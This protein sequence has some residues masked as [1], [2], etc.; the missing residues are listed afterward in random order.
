M[1][2]HRIPTL[3]KVFGWLFTICI[4]GNLTCWAQAPAN[5]EPGFASPE[6]FEAIRAA[7]V[8][9]AVRITDEISLD[10]RL[11]EAAWKLAT[12]ATDFYQHVPLTG[13]PAAERTEVFFLYDDNNL[14]MGVICYYLDPSQIQV[15]ELK[16]DF[17]YQ[18]SDD[19]GIILDTLHDRR[20]GLSFAVNAAGAKRDTQVS[21]GVTN[22][23]WDAVWDA[24]VTRNDGG[25]VS[26]FVIPF[27]TL[28]FPNSPTQE[29]GLNMYRR[30]L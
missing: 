8:V 2:A 15:T 9:K 29:W 26:E 1:A 3:M 18:E 28:R 5:T 12:P 14:Y 27:K 10:G 24:K 23:D 30:V 20:S 13:A 4:V 22:Q 11:D 17:V 25:Y 6:S 16:K 19:F 7:K 21:I